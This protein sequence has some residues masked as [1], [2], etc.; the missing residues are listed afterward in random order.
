MILLV[1]RLQSVFFSFLC[2]CIGHI[3]WI[4]RFP[5]FLYSKTFS[6]G[7]CGPQAHSYPRI[8]VTNRV[9]GGFRFIMLVLLEIS[10]LRRYAEYHAVLSSW[11]ILVC[12]LHECYLV[13]GFISNEQFIRSTRFRLD[14]HITNMCTQC[15]HEVHPA[16]WHE[17]HRTTQTDQFLFGVWMYDCT[18]KLHAFVERKRAR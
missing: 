6:V 15:G 17:A 12:G 7:F 9:F 10:F 11:C 14:A 2:R 5:W 16:T 13:C 8:L 1:K 4:E 3:C 18:N